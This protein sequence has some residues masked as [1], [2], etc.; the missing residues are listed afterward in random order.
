MIKT[1]RPV[2]NSLGLIIDRPILKLL[3]IDRK[4]Q[5]RITTDGKILYIE[6]VVTDGSANTEPSSG[7]RTSPG[8]NASRP[9]GDTSGR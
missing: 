4:T 7:R 8:S 1:L 9:T 6:P 3:G 2:G 5:L